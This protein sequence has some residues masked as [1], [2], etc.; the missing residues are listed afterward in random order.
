[1]D[2][3]RPRGELRT[4]RL[5]GKTGERFLPNASEIVSRSVANLRIIRTRRCIRE[6]SML[7]DGG[8]SR[9]MRIS[10][11]DEVSRHFFH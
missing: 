2:R 7:I 11:C 4:N 3:V 5:A 1:M 8:L 6:F 10:L 9:K